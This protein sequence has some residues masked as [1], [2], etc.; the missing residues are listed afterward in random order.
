MKKPTLLVLSLA[1]VL[2]TACATDGK[3]T[4]SNAGDKAVQGGT[5]GALG[6]FAACK[7]LGGS[8][9]TCTAVGVATGAVGAAVGWKQGKELDLAKAREFEQKVKAQNIPVQTESAVIKQEDKAAGKTETVEAW[10][11]TNVGLP[12]TMLSKRS[13]DLQKAVELSG[14]IAATRNEQTRI[15][16]AAA[17]ADRQVVRSWVDAGVARSQPKKSNPQIEY[18]PLRKGDVAFVRI[19]P[20]NQAQFA[21]GA[22]ASRS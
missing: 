20:A 22:A 16:I 10:K 5:I 8:N 12:T 3:M 21:Q 19:E 14:E 9:S 11:G 4:G 15:L 17:D 1:T 13:P 7:L 2:A 18:V 6:G